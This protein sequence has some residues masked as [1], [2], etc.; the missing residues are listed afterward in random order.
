MVRSGMLS[1]IRQFAHRVQHGEKTWGFHD[2][3]V[4]SLIR[5]LGNFCDMTVTSCRYLLRL[6]YCT[7]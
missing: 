7:L 4:G 1:I 5:G 2:V 3:D 6:C